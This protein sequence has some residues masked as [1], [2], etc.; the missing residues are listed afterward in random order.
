[1]KLLQV[2]L[3]I[4]VIFQSQ[5]NVGSGALAD[6]L[7]D[8]PALKDAAQ[9]PIVPGSS[10]KGRARHECE[11]IVRALT[12]Q[13]N[14]V[15]HGPMAETMCPLGR[16][17]KWPTEEACPVCRIF[18]SPWLPAVAQFSDLR[19]E[20]WDDFAGK[21]PP[22]TALRYGVSIGRT[23]RVAEEHK[24]FT[25][26]AFAP[27]KTTTY[28]GHIRGNFPDDTTERHGQVGLLVTGLRGIT[29]LGGARSRG[30]GWCQITVTPAEIFDGQ[31]HLMD[32][33]QLKEGLKQWLNLT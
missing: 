28:T 5:F 16:L 17:D 8:K 33:D 4:Q 2:N 27:T 19:W 26:E 29:S 9:L 1:V 7:A 25:T 21:S 22:G 14:R 18:G 12:G 13:E 11:R 30:M 10:L 6:S 15:C 3:D 20:F 31:G 23:R 32:D 24:L